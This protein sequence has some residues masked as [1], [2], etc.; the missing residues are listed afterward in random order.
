M[1]LLLDILSAK[2]GMQMKDKSRVA[3]L[4]V[5]IALGTM[6]G[7]GAVLREEE[8]AA[9]S[10]Q[11]LLGEMQGYRLFAGSQVQ[12][13]ERHFT[14]QTL[15]K[16]LLLCISEQTPLP[17]YMPVQQA[18]NMR[19]MIGLYVPA[20]PDVSLSE[21]TIYALCALCEE[22]PLLR[23]WVID[24]MRSP[25]EQNALQN[26]AFERYRA[27]YP[28]AQALYL[29]R[30]EAPTGG[31]SEHQLS[32]A[33]DLQFQGTLEW[34]YADPLDRCKDGRWLREN[35][36]RFGFIRRYPPDKTDITGV[37][38]EALHFRYVGKTHA[39]VMQVTGWCLEE[40]LV[41]L[42]KH[43]GLTVSCE[44]GKNL[45]ILCREM[46]ESGAAFPCP[47]GYDA[48]PS[49]DNQG[50]AVCVLTPAQASSSEES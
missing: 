21:E 40:Y 12:G 47:A 42:K 24:G 37:S 28:V 22:N 35:A 7:C 44:D 31:K 14:R 13:E 9:F 4:L 30:Q 23:T 26:E 3:L 2:G 43:Q 49:A 48:A 45:Y 19:K 17:E 1:C 50:Y 5:L 33:F 18:R 36:W 6:L 25:A 39:L 46:T 16:G 8:A 11:A 27:Q 20:A 38:T 41:A 32:T 10:Q 34:S 29:A 15:F